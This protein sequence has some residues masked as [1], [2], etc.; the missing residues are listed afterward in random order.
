MFQKKG[1]SRRGIFL[2]GVPRGLTTVVMRA[3]GPGLLEPFTQ[4]LVLKKGLKVPG[5]NL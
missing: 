1:K 4:A 5:F 2:I 3:F